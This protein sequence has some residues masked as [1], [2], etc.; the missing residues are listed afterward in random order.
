MEDSI[1]IENT[2]K[3]DSVIN[4]SF[5]IFFK[6]IIAFLILTLCVFVPLDLITTYLMSNESTRITGQVLGFFFSIFAGYFV[7]GAIILGVF[8]YMQ[9]K[10]FSIA[11]CIEIVGQRFWSLLGASILAGIIIILGGLL[12]VVPGIIAAVSFAVITPVVVVERV[13]PIEALS[14]SGELTQGRRWQIFGIYI[15]LMIITLVFSIIGGGLIGVIATD[16][17]IIRSLLTSVIGG[18]AGTFNA[19][20]TVVIYYF[21]KVEK[22]DV[23]IE[24]IAEVFS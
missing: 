21:L 3:V 17:T 1:G 5:E 10:P 6:N 2:F 20:I 8:K 11:E 9:E 13:G 15:I 24:E 23:G 14:R 12:L 4:K 16:V 18:I 22:E 19:V 7:A